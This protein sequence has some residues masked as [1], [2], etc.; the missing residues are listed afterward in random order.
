M[1]ENKQYWKFIEHI[2]ASPASPP[3]PSL[4]HQK[5]EVNKI[6]FKVASFYPLFFYTQYIRLEISYY[7]CV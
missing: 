2:S 7:H 1:A 3:S 4:L 6:K 5:S